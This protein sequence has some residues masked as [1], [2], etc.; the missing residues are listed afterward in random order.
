M[1]GSLRIREADGVEWSR[2]KGG[3]PLLLLSAKVSAE[4]GLLER[5]DC[6]MSRRAEVSLR[7]TFGVG[8]VKEVYETMLGWR[9]GDRGER[10]S[11]VAPA[12]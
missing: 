7:R 8:A 9:G 11:D 1:L 10:S 2:G 3:G 12:L 4:N 6:S 5:S